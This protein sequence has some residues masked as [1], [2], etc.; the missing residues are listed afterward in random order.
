M[1]L[2][3]GD[4]HYKRVVDLSP[5]ISFVLIVVLAFWLSNWMGVAVS[6]QPACY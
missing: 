3:A 4:V 2:G 5:Y 1:V 6:E